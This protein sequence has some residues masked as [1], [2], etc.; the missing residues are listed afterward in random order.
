MVRDMNGRR[1]LSRHER[2]YRREAG[3]SLAP[4][5]G[6]SDG[7]EV[8]DG[9]EEEVWAEDQEGG[10]GYRR[11]RRRLQPPAPSDDPHPYQTTPLSQGYGT[12]YAT[13]YVG[14]PVP[15]RK[16]VIVDT[17]SHFT[18]FPCRG[19]ENC[20]ESSHTNRH[21]DPEASQTFRH[22]PCGECTDA[23]S[24]LANLLGAETA[25]SVDV[26]ARSAQAKS[27]VRP[28]PMTPT[29]RTG[30]MATKACQISS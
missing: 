21:F 11:R 14:S 24:T 20:G 13:I 29:V 1:H 18:A 17:G 2:T 26:T 23:A 5:P 7:A 15:Q 9:A 19:C 4:A 3:I 27:Y 16:T 22:V 28:S 10:N 25:A 8:G 6:E 12:H 30:R